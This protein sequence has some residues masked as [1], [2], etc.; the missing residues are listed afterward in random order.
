MWHDLY[1]ELLDNVVQPLLLH[2]DKSAL[3]GAIVIETLAQT[4]LLFECTLYSGGP[5]I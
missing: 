3:L 5:D 4:S 1:T 2:S